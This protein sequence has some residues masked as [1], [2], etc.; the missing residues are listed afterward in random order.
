MKNFGKLTALGSILCVAL[1]SGCAAKAVDPAD[2]D[3]TGAYD[4]VWLGSVGGPRA[5]Q[6]DLPGNWVMQCGWEPFEIYMVV[7]D[8]RIQL[9]RMEIKTPVSTR[10]DF[11]LD[12][13]SG[14][15]EMIGGI[16]SG[17]GQFVDVFSGNLSGT[18]PQGKYFQFV[19]SIGADGCSGPI[20]FTLESS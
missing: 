3:T 17:N 8:G 4:G 2:R 13:N 12:I 10:G 18:N 7:D 11:R 5:D 19:T 15:A 14:D 16:M 6:V 20:Q 1:L 9:G